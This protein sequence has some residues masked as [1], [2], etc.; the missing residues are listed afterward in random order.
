VALNGGNEY[1]SGLYPS[2]R[3]PGYSPYNTLNDEN[4]LAVVGDDPSFESD[5][6]LQ[7]SV[8]WLPI[9][10]CVGG[11]AFFRA[12]AEMFL[13][14]EP[15]ELEDA[16]RR[17]VSR[18]T[19]SPFTVRIAEQA[20]GLVLRKPIVL[21]SKQQD[22][23]VDPY[24]EEFVESIDGRGT[25]LSAFARRVLISSLLYGH[26]GC[27]C[28]YP[29][30]EAAPSLQAERLA[31]MRPYFHQVDAKQI[32]GWRFEEGNPLSPVQQV[33]INEYVSVPFGEFGDKTIRQIRV[34]EPGSYRVYRR[35]ADRDI[36]TNGSGSQGWYIHEEGN[37]SLNVVPLALTYSQKISEFVSAPPLLSIANLN[38]SHAQRNAD[39]AHGLHVAAMPIMVLK[40]FD[41]A[42][43]PAGLS[44]NNAI[45]LP[46][47]GDAFMVEPASQSFDA[48]Q[49]Y[50]TQLEEQMA[51]LGISTL[52]AQKQSAE[53][54][55]SK[56]LSRT[57]S[58]SLLSIVSK[59][60]EGMLQTAFEMAGAYVGKEAPKV[61]LDKDYDLQVLDGSQVGQYLQLWTQGAITQE[62]L[63]NALKKG[64]ILPGIDIEEE[65]EL[66]SQEKLD[67]MLME[68]IPSEAAAP[69]DSEGR[70]QRDASVRQA[71]VD[72][73]RSQVASRDEDEE[74]S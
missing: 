70:E 17:R 33:R 47:E 52:F 61:I 68:G 39:L 13:S 23:E 15:A 24:W 62:T 40:G 18:A 3:P 73:M 43:D 63:L 54:A 26:A 69:A 65:V 72:R 31:G 20:A 9:D 38:I 6:Y 34:L 12:N 37:I 50:L 14:Q 48:Q 42:P 53:T 21:E 10:C 71:A 57:D 36:E 41:D 66:T 67:S 28:D 51:S 59:D 11:T 2:Q 1:V 7:M 55:E 19:F 44:V 8:H 58:D 30:R 5:G 45:L 60:L 32:I 29:S 64:E 16:W 22:G 56:R 46:P 35:E 25:S 49:S 74:E 27:L 4:N